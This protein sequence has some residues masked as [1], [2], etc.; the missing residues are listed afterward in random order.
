MGDGQT[1]KLT[2][3]RNEPTYLRFSQVIILG[4][5]THPVG[6][7]KVHKDNLRVNNSLYPLLMVWV[8]FKWRKKLYKYFLTQDISKSIEDRA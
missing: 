7:H 4:E 6:G 8:T 2:N 1:D 3:T 5:I